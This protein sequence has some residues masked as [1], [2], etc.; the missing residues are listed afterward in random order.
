MYYESCIRSNPHSEIA[1]RCFSRY[2]QNVHFG[3]T[4]SGG[5]AIPDDVAALLKELGQLAGPKQ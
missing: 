2:E 3:W 4:G 1:Q 5:F